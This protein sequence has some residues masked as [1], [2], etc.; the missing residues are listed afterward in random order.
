VDLAKIRRPFSQAPV[1]AR[2][3]DPA[4]KETKKQLNF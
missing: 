3:A 1:S 4:K 2:P